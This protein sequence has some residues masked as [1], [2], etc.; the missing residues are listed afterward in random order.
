MAYRYGG[1]QKSLALGAYPAIAL[2][3]AREKRDAAKR[4]LADQVDPAVQRRLDKLNAASPNTFR[5]LAEELLRKLE[6]EKRAEVTI[7][8][9]RW[10]LSFVFPTIGDRPVNE[11]SAPEV[12][13]VLRKIEARG[14]YE[15]AQRLRS[16]CGMVF[17]YAVVNRR[18]TLTPYRRPMLTPLSD[19]F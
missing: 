10:L 5:A 6:R 18:P 4:L 14:R 1:K 9:K 3:H 16:T 15:T 11:I 8:K 7:A 13:S 19:G 12:L 17:R 2:K